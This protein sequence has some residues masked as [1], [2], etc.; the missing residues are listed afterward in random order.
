MEI[1]NKSFAEVVPFE[2]AKINNCVQFG[3]LLWQV[4]GIEDGKK[5]LIS[6]ECMQIDFDWEFTQNNSSEIKEN[7]EDIATHNVAK[8]DIA[9]LLHSCHAG[10]G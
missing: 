5:L 9:V 1:K 7:I 2:V 6:K 8:S 3:E 10:S 4:I